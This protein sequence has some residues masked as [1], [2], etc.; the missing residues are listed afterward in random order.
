MERA[1]RGKHNHA[2]STCCS[3]Y[4]ILYAVTAGAVTNCALQRCR[5]DHTKGEPAAFGSSD[6]TNAD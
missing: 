3:L 2:G 4:W 1:V 6:Q 5:V